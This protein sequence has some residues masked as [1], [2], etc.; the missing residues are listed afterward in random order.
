LV[1][2]AHATMEESVALAKKYPQFNVVITSGGNPIP[3]DEPKKIE[4]SKT[5]FVE[6]GLKGMSAIVL[7]FYDDKTTP[8][9]YQRVVLD[10]RRSF[11]DKAKQGI[12]SND[13]PPSEMKHLMDAFQN[14]IKEIGFEGLGLRASPHPQKEIGGKFVGSE[15]CKS[16][17]EVSYKVWKKS[18]HSKAYKTL[19]ELGTPRNFDPECVSCHVIGWNPQRFFPYETGFQSKEKTPHLTDVGCE[20]CHGPGENHCKAEEGSDEAKMEKYRKAAVITKAES[21]KNQCRTCHDGDNSPDFN[22]Q[23]YWPFIEHYENKE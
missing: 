20:S 14:E 5:L 16:C 17:H 7:G 21:E 10:S 9:R 19:A 15:K 22:F 3:P 2:L 8:V 23:K 12:V 13:P 11:L 4:G 1:L 6:V 18:L